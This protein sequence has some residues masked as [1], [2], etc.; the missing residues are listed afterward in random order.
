MTPT[1]CRRGTLNSHI[2]PVGFPEWGWRGQCGM[3]SHAKDP[4]ADSQGCGPEVSRG[5]GEASWGRMCSQEERVRWES[6]GD[7]GSSYE[8]RTC[9]M[10]HIVTTDL[11][12]GE[13]PAQESRISNLAVN[14]LDHRG[15]KR[16]DR[17]FPLSSSR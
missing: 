12:T 9:Q 4:V 7:S 14:A 10:G 1:L 13:L 6:G 8:H 15:S 16:M 11:H 17:G 3:Q 2:S 5:S